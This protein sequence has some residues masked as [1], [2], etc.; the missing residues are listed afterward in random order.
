MEIRNRLPSL[1]FSRS[2]SVFLLESLGEIRR[3]GETYFV[4]YF[5][6]VL[7]GGF[8][9]AL[10]LCQTGFAKEVYH[11][12]SGERLHLAIELHTAEPH[13][14]AKVFYGIV[15]IGDVALYGIAQLGDEG[16]VFLAES[17]LLL[18]F[19][20]EPEKMSF[21]CERLFS[22]LATRAIR[23]STENGLVM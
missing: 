10:C 17:V 11:R 15:G 3:S 21:S 16:L 1:H 9:Q 18:L 14:A 2:H 5:G 12:I 4:G 8:E 23:V 20:C 6:D 7:V 19:L 13:L 22:R